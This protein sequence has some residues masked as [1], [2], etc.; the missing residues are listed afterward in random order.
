VDVN[1]STL[2]A[3]V[4]LFDWVSQLDIVKVADVVF[5]H[6]G[7][8]TIK[9]SIWEQV[10]IVIVPLGKDQRDNALRIKRAGVGVEAEVADLSPTDLRKLF[11]QATSSTWVRQNLA[12]M[13]G[14]FQAAEAAKPSINIIKSVFAGP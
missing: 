9:E 8:A 10:P 5:M 4:A 13:K 11:T 12:T 6:G 7:L 3:N 14:I 2:P 1:A